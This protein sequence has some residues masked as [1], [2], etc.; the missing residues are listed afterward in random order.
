MPKKKEEPV[1]EVAPVKAK[2]EPVKQ[3]AK[4]GV[5]LVRFRCGA[6]LF[7]VGDVFNGDNAEAEVLREKG[8]IS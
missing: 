2:E 8:L 4:K 6:G 5:A 1:K 3:T 7:Q